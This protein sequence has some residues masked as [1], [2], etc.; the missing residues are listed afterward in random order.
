M[1]KSSYKCTHCNQTGHTKGRCFELVG[2]PE[3]W[4]HSHSKKKGPSTAAIANT[5]AKDG[6]T[7]TA[8]ALVIAGDN[9]GKFLNISTPVCDNT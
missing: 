7:N 3:W 6:I 8:S 2:Y 9:G 5:T 4:D 1:D